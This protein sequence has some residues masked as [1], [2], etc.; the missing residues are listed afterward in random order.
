[1]NLVFKYLSAVFLVVFLWFTSSSYGLELNNGHQAAANDEAAAAADLAA[2]DAPNKNDW[3]AYIRQQNRFGLMKRGA[4]DP[5]N[6]FSA[7]YDNYASNVGGYR[8]RYSPPAP[9]DYY[10]PLVYSEKRNTMNGNQ[11]DPRNLFRAI[12]GYR[13]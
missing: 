11:L 6:L 8:K 4:T 12:Y 9:V 10:Q 7:I 1:M 13:K 2:L 3:L 5:R